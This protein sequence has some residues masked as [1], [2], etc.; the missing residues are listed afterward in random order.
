MKAVAFVFYITLNVNL[1]TAISPHPFIILSNFTFLEWLYNTWRHI[2][3]GLAVM[4][5]GWSERAKFEEKKSLFVRKK[6]YECYLLRL[7]SHRRYWPPDILKTAPYYRGLWMW[8]NPL[9]TPTPTGWQSLP[10]FG[11]RWRGCLNLATGNTIG[12]LGVVSIDLWSDYNAY[13]L[14]SITFISSRFHTTILATG[15]VSALPVWQCQPNGSS[16]Y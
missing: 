1:N 16:L 14:F 5:D 10:E 13:F 4:H 8:V 11:I 12:N 6:E 2:Y 15:T 7:I 9:Q 3:N